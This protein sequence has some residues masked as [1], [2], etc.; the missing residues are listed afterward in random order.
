MKLKINS[1]IREVPEAET[2][3]D[4]LK[5]M[6]YEGQPVAVALNGDFVARSAYAQT[7]LSENDELEIVAPI[8]GG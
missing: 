2:I 8:A 7:D 5:Q 6:G 4:V 3:L 1:E